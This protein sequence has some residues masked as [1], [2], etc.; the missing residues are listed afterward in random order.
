MNIIIVYAHPYDGSFCK[1]LLD[2]VS[3]RLQSRGAAV[4]VKDLVKMKFDAVMQPDDLKAA[5]TEAYTDEVKREQADVLWADAIVTIAP[6]WFGAMPGFLKG[7]FDKVFMTKFAYDERIGGKLQ[8]KR[9]FSLFTAGS[10]DPYLDMAGQYECINL[11][12]DNLFGS[13]GFVDV[14]T[15]FYQSVP[16]VTAEERKQYLTEAIQF[17]DQI[18]DCQP[19]EV[20]QVGHGGL[21]TKLHMQGYLNGRV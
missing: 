16:I 6:I 5:R 11:S 18:F 1:G 21:L 17:V 3:S 13:T 12:M 10:N 4:K 14:A 15:K 2:T 7:Y 20:G 19:G 8:G 9:V